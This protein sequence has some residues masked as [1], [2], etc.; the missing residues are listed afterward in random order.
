LIVL[1]NVTKSYGIKTVVKDFSLE[2]QRGQI[3][4][5][6]GP[7]GC[8]KTTTLRMINRM[9]DPTSGDIF[10]NGFNIK[11]I[12]PDRLR[13]S[14]G[15]AIQMVGLFPHMDVFANIAAVPHL[16]GWKK[17]RIKERVEELL[18]LVGLKSHEYINKF[19]HQ[20]SGGEAQRVGVARALAADPGILLMDE[21][22]GAV[23]PLTR[24]KLQT[25]FL[26]IQKRLKKTIILV[27]HD[28][29]EAIRLADKIAIMKDGQ[30]IQYDSPEEILSRPADKFVYDFVG[31]DRALKRLSRINVDKYVTQAPFVGEAVPK[32]YAQKKCGACRWI[33]VVDGSHKLTG[34]IDSEILSKSSSVVEAVSRVNPSD[35]S[36]TKDSSLKEALSVM[37]SQGL[38]TIPVVEN[39][40]YLLGEV[41]MRVIENALAEKG[42]Q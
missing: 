24:A 7:S 15:Y 31:S 35:I 22:F 28:L 23:D 16:L 36:V 4:V 8:G 3:C 30:L 12:R 6:I 10:I 26:N 5:L 42:G 1:K 14:M 29:D 34:W 39:D 13:R 11:K 38:K 37:L 41:D 17:E 2:V 21:P 40:G 32:E 18:L 9:A 19:P 20:L 25:Q 27:T 33:W